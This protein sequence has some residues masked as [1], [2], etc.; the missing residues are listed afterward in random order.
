MSFQKETITPPY[1]NKI[2]H[3]YF[4]KGSDAYVSG[5][6]KILKEDFIVRN[7][8]SMV[9]LNNNASESLEKDALIQL[10]DE[11][12]EFSKD[13]FFALRMMGMANGTTQDT[14]DNESGV[15]ATI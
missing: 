15:K 9:T 8:N 3:V 11:N 2:F 1:Q 14:H 5:F 12:D 7:N 10:M 13:L 4:I 6:V